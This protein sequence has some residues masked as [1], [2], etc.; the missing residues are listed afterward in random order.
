MAF[1]ATGWLVHAARWR[2]SWYGVTDD[3]AL[4]DL[5]PLLALLAAA[6]N[7]PSWA[8]VV[9]YYFLNESSLQP[10]RQNKTLKPA[11]LPRPPCYAMGTAGALDLRRRRGCAAYG[12]YPFMHG[13]LHLLSHELHQ[14]SLSPLG[15]LLARLEDAWC[16]AGGDALPGSALSRH[17]NLS[18]INLDGAVGRFD[19]DWRHG[20]W[21]GA[22]SLLAHRVRTHEAFEFAL[23]EFNG[24]RRAHAAGGTPGSDVFSAYCEAPAQDASHRE[25]QTRFCRGAK[26]QLPCERWVMQDPSVSSLPCCQAWNVCFT[27]AAAPL[28]RTRLRTTHR[29]QRQS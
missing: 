6:P 5:P 3:D 15:A 4:I 28:P 21:S 11:W 17:P 14:W 27:P 9:S 13:A 20:K 10:A 22:Q 23:Q 18:L 26:L 16:P 24:T 25:G 7:G 12:P 19:V 8:G 29:M 2:A 1:K